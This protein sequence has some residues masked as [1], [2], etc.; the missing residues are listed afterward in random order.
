MHDR[1]DSVMRSAGFILGEEVELFEKEF[2]AFTGA[3]HCIGVANGTEAIHLALREA[4]IGPGDE[5]IVPVNTFIATALAV[6]YTGARP[7]FADADEA[8]STID[9]R[10]AERRITKRTKAILPVHL[11]G[12]PADMD[13]IMG[14]AAAHRLTVIEDA[15]QAHGTKYR[16]RPVGT[17]GRSGCFSFYPGKNL[18]A[19][20]D[21][22]AV[23]AME[24]EVAERIR[25][26]RNYGQR[27]KYEHAEIGY[28][29]RLDS[30][31]A[32]VL[33]V[34]LQRLEQWNEQRRQAA[35]RY[36][37]SLP[38]GV[39]LPAAVSNA[40]HVY[41]LYVVRV[42]QREALMAHL[43]EQGV[44]TGIHYPIPLHQ[45]ECFRHLGYSAGDFPVAERMAPEILSLPMYPEI[46]AEQTAYVADRVNAFYKGSR[47]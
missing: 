8:T 45:Q 22:G 46:T 1:L 47:A 38:K 5:V 2:A 43:K 31:Q 37:E 35:Q 33:R 19:Y 15:C 3:R 9:L 28:N 14:L 18:G 29:C 4:G 42:A 11:Y 13:G 40:T 17:F 20:G 32:A 24:A 6:V 27:S 21:G 7:V 12:R 44:D 26:L 30:L 34:K 36:S 41:H 39:G 25:R 23:V 16:G 10:D